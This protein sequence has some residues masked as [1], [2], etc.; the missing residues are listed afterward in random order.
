MTSEPLE[1]LLSSTTTPLSPAVRLTSARTWLR[2]LPEASGGK[3]SRQRGHWQQQIHSRKPRVQSVRIVTGLHGKAQM[4]WQKCDS[5]RNI[6]IAQRLVRINRATSHE[7]Y[8]VLAFGSEQVNCSQV[9]TRR[10][11]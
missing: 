9:S 11:D 2:T 6:P 3:T 4:N 10:L 5:R 8:E 1:K 7:M